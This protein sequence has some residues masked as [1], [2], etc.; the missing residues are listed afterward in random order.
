M[1]VLDGVRAWV[2]VW[3]GVDDWLSVEDA[4]IDAE[5]LPLCEVVWDI[6]LDC[7]L[8][9]D[10]VAVRLGVVCAGRGEGETCPEPLLP[11]L[12]LTHRWRAGLG[13]RRGA[14]SGACAG[15]CST[16]RARSRLRLGLRRR[17]CR[18]PRC[19]GGHGR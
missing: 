7:E 9:E 18:C 16:L 4:L 15:L 13:S 10:I 6:E 19:R 11:A 5:K 3:D 14:S 8:D 12:T 1:G 2:G 17:L